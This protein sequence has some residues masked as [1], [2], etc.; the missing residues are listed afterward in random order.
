MKIDNI[1]LQQIRSGL[2]GLEQE[3]AL[4]QILISLQ[5][6]D[7]ITSDIER[8]ALVDQIIA[9]INEVRE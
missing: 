6:L 1:R 7:A 8:I 5:E 3:V 9:A 2:S 4:F